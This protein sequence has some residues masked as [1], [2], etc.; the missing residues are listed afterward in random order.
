MNLF[1]RNLKLKTCDELSK[2]ACALRSGIAVRQGIHCC[3]RPQP[4]MNKVIKVKDTNQKP[5][6][7]CP[8]HN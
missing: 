1:S 8:A 3:V 6:Y 5:N 2:P 7:A 4:L